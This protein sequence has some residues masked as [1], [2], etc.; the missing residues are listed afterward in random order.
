MGHAG[1]AHRHVWAGLGC[2]MTEVPLEL[3][4]WRE[5]R[6]RVNWKMLVVGSCGGEWVDYYCVCSEVWNEPQ[7]CVRSFVSE[8]RFSVFSV[9]QVLMI[10]L[11]FAENENENCCVRVE[12]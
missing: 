11:L 3:F 7:F 12:T 9:F 4:D 6:N 2:G 8:L 5:G 10:L 1:A